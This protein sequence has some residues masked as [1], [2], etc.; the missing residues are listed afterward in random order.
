M[1]WISLISPPPLLSSFSHLFNLFIHFL[2]ALIRWLK[3]IFSFT[4]LLSLNNELDF[5][6]PGVNLISASVLHIYEL[7]SRTAPLLYHL[8]MEN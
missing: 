4:D 1:G 8:T 2:S 6:S 5:F 7:V 3:F